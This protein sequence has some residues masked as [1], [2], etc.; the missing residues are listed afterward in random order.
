MG[1]FVPRKS[2]PFWMNVVIMVIRAI[3]IL[4]MYYYCRFGSGSLVLLI[5]MMISRGWFVVVDWIGLDGTP[6]ACL[7][8]VSRFHHLDPWPPCRQ[9]TAISMPT[10]LGC[11]IPF[12]LVTN[13]RG[14]GDYFY[15][16]TTTGG[17]TGTA[18]REGRPGEPG[19]VPGAHLGPPWSISFPPSPALRHRDG[20]CMDI[21]RPFQLSGSRSGPSFNDFGRH[22]GDRDK[23]GGM[24][25]G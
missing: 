25:G 10:F 20:P 8:P 21:L 13:G 7:A 1:I 3:I 5:I 15:P 2:D 9:S 16:R 19:P 22:W 12:S 18:T 23:A 4:M 24:V 6:L 17:R 14:K 11:T